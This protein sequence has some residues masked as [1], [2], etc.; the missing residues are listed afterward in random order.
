MT[1]QITN[2]EDEKPFAQYVIARDNVRSIVN[3]GVYPNIKKVLAELS[4]FNL[5]L[6]PGGDMEQFKLYDEKVTENVQPEQAQ[7]VQLITA[8]AQIVEGIELAAPGTFPAAAK[9]VEV[10][11]LP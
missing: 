9:I 10:E 4:A 3:F 1:L 11:P 6:Q 5:R 2:Y 7:M 8:F